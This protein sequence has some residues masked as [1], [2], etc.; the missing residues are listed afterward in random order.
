MELHRSYDDLDTDDDDD[1][2]Y[3]ALRP[4]K[5]AT[6]GLPPMPDLRFEQSYLHSIAHAD[7]WW[8]VALITAKDQVCDKM[9]EA[10]GC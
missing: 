1:I 2:P 4:A 3:S 6:H 10:N 7:T 9:H 8:K 5:P